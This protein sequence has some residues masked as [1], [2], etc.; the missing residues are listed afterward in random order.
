VRRYCEQVPDELKTFAA[1]LKGLDDRVDA[2]S[3]FRYVLEEAEVDSYWNVKQSRLRV[4]KTLMDVSLNL[5]TYKVL[6]PH[7][8][9]L[10]Y[11]LP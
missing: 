4:E 9:A 6:S 10:N 8:F 3:A 11:C 2:L 1:A 7:C 5:D